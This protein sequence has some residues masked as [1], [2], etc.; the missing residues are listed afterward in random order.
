MSSAYDT[1][2]TTGVQMACVLQAGRLG[3]AYYDPELNEVRA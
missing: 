1:D 2:A 3:I